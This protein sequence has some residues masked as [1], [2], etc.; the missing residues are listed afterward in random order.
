MQVPFHKPHLTGKEIDFIKEA[1]DNNNLQGNQKFS[2]K[3][4]QLIEEQLCAKKVFLTPS[5]TS[6]LEMAADIFDIGPGDEVIIPSY[7]FV[8]T[9]NAFIT[10]GATPVFCDIDPYTLNMNPHLHGIPI[11][12]KTKAIVVVHYAG[13]SVDMDPLKKK[14]DE[15]N[16]TR[17]ANNYKKLFL[18]EDAAQAYLSKYKNQYCGTI[19]D[20]GVVSFHS[21][22]NI[23]SGEGGGLIFGEDETFIK[24]AE[25]VQ[26]KGTD[27]KQMIQGKVDKY[28]WQHRG[29]SYLMNEITAAF[30]YAQLLEAKN[31]TKRRVHIWHQYKKSL[32]QFMNPNGYV[33]DIP[34]PEKMTPNGHIYCIKFLDPGFRNQ[35]MNEMK[36][37][38]IETQEHFVPLH[39][40][41][42]GKK[43]GK[44]PQP[45]THTESL[46]DAVVRLPLRST[47]TDQEVNK[48]LE[49]LNSFFH[50][51]GWN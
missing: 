12:E 51:H 9:A 3:C 2:Q 47:L 6:A 28:T 37:H 30:L 43:H 19:G 44:V 23:Q 17:K 24:K 36:G 41:P 15:I 7:T 8:S 33:H 45:L 10:R 5:G 18:I 13:I 49:T 1:I 34:I 11:T 22:K 50:N 14:I 31:I 20:V 29:S 38:G 32:S 16:K 25:I 35:F 42:F 21:T 48:I 46:K 27:R 40:S 4:C 26:E 39:L